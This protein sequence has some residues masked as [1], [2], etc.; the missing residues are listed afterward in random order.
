M[1]HPRLHH[2]PRPE[3]TNHRR[4]PLVALA[5]LHEV[6]VGSGSDTAPSAP[7]GGDGGPSRCHNGSGHQGRHGEPAIRP[8][9]HNGCC[10]SPATGPRHRSPSGRS[11]CH[12]GPEHPTSTSMDRR[13]RPGKGPDE[14]STSRRERALVL[15][16]TARC[17]VGRPRGIDVRS[18][19]PRWD[20]ASRTPRRVPRRA[21]PAPPACR[22]AHRSPHSQRY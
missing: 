20:P 22:L 10:E 21:R 14:P 19:P 4:D 9:D 5:S 8:P 13:H 12:N 2:E 17:R 3:G 6:T 11:A 15:C 7:A 1:A 16:P 18:V